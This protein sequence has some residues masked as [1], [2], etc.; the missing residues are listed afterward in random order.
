M[1]LEIF[2]RNQRV[3]TNIHTKRLPTYVKYRLSTICLPVFH[4]SNRANRS[5][6]ISNAKKNYM[7]A[8]VVT[9]AGWRISGFNADSMKNIN[10]DVWRKE[11]W[12]TG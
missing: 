5:T 6:N 8:T 3:K 1:W 4:L 9:S 10:Q 12:Q 11:D 7:Y 2:A